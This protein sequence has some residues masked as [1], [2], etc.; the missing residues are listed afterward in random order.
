MVEMF[1]PSKSQPLVDSD[2]DCDTDSVGICVD[3][4]Y[5]QFFRAMALR[6]F[7]DPLRCAMESVSIREIRVPF[8]MAAM[9]SR[10]SRLR[11]STQR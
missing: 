8:V 6:F 3:L 5:L 10:S 11:G 2:C 1:V 9:S 7:G 4:R